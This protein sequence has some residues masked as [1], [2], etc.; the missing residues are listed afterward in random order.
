ML[1]LRRHIVLLSDPDRSWPALFDVE[2]ERIAKAVAGMEISIEHIG[3][4]AVPDLPAKPILDIGILLARYEDLDA[5]KG[6]L[7]EIGY[8]GRGDKGSEGGYLFAQECGPGVRTHH[9]HV[10]GPGD[11]AWQD[12]IC[13][14][15]ALRY[16]P[17]LRQRYASLKQ[18]SADRFSDNRRAYSKTKSVFIRNTLAGLKTH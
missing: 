12:Y 4:T 15:D 11:T 17:N 8:I 7:T 1:G 2:R 18:D 5:F 6:A 14:R 9:V 16:D 13:F 10:I 3:S